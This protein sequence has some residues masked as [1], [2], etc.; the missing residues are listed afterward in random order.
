[1]TGKRW[2]SVEKA[3]SLIKRCIYAFVLVLLVVVV[4]MTTSSQDQSSFPLKFSTDVWAWKAELERDMGL[5]W[6]LNTPSADRAVRFMTLAIRHAIR[7]YMNS[8]QTLVIIIVLT[9]F[10]NSWLKQLYIAA[11][12][13]MTDMTDN[14]LTDMGRSFSADEGECP[15]LLVDQNLANGLSISGSHDSWAADRPVDHTLPSRQASFSDE[16]VQRFQMLSKKLSKDQS[17]KN[18]N[19]ASLLE[20][21]R[22]NGGEEGGGVEAFVF[23]DEFG[24][25]PESSRDRWQEQRAASATKR[26]EQKTQVKKKDKD[27]PPVRYSTAMRL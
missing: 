11:P 24:S 4:C 14:M 27:L 23:D 18:E 15:D 17:W 13:W 19:L 6:R 1:M 3:K 20:Q 10:M 5:I 16:D 25:I 22:G 12:V 21:D 9:S 7:L 2:L 8:F 26:E